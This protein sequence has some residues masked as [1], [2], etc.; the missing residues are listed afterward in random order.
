M[1]LLLL[2]FLYFNQ[3]NS[4]QHKD[5]SYFFLHV[6]LYT[7][8]LSYI[9]MPLQY[10]VLLYFHKDCHHP[11]RSCQSVCLPIVLSLSGL[12]LPGPPHLSA[13]WTVWAISHLYL[14]VYVRMPRLAMGVYV[15]EFWTKFSP[16]LFSCLIK[17]L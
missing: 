1:L 15:K 5:D 6:Q 2:L 3:Y 9:E 7:C 16:T 13:K 4:I 10:N 11:S 12:H 8:E 14:T 17:H